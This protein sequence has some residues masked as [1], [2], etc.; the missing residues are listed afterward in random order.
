MQTGFVIPWTWIILG[1]FICTL[2]GLL[3]GLYPAFKA[4]KLNPIEALRYE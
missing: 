1:I 4:A 3:A 2:V